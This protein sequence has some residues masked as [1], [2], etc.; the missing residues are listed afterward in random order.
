MEKDREIENIKRRML[1]MER[2]IVRQDEEIRELEEKLEGRERLED[3]SDSDAGKEDPN[4]EEKSTENAESE[5]LEEVRKRQQQKAYKELERKELDN[6]EGKRKLVIRKGIAW[7]NR[8]VET[9][10]KEK[11]NMNYDDWTLEPLNKKD[12]HHEESVKGVSK[13]EFMRP[14]HAL[15]TGRSDI[16]AVIK[17]DYYVVKPSMQKS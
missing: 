5:N 3:Y 17:T 11:T 16:K 14:K 12:N 7:R 2:L 13:D 9:W 10:I 6:R 15:P 4:S 8:Y 1:R